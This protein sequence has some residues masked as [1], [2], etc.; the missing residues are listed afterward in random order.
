MLGVGCSGLLGGGDDQLFPPR[1][2]PSL[3]LPCVEWNPSS[4]ERNKCFSSDAFHGLK[5][6]GSCLGGSDS[7]IRTWSRLP[8]GWFQDQAPNAQHAGIQPGRFH[9]GTRN[10]SYFTGTHLFLTSRKCRSKLTWFI[11]SR[12][13][14][15]VRC[16]VPTCFACVVFC[17]PS[18]VKMSSL[19]VFVIELN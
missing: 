6:E 3:C 2:P 15:I 19:D 17:S 16:L 4:A 7:C 8:N 14:E 11:T 13:E 12:L 18:F 9:P 5:C 1:M 10:V